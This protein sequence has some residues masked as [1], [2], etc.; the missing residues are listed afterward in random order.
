MP[1]NDLLISI[2]EL[3]IIFFLIFSIVG[4]L[5]LALIRSIIDEYFRDLDREKE[6]W[7]P[8]IDELLTVSSLI[9]TVRRPKTSWEKTG[10][11]L[12]LTE[13]TVTDPARYR[14]LCQIVNRYSIDETLATLYR[15]S[16]I[17]FRKTFYLSTLADLPCSNQR[18]LYLRL[19]RKT[20]SERTYTMAL[21]GLSKSIANA[22]EAEE[23]FRLLLETGQKFYLG[24]NY[25]ELLI[26]I[27]LRHMEPSEIRQAIDYLP[28]DQRIA[29]CVTESLGRFRQ[30]K[31]Q[32]Y[33]R[34]IYRN[35]HRDPEI[36]AALIRSLF[37]SE[38]R[39]CDLMDDLLQ[40]PELPVRINVAKFGLDLCPD[41]DEVMVKL[42]K[43]FF[44]RNYYVRQ[45]VYRA[46]IRH[47]VPAKRIRDI[48]TRHYPEMASDLFFKE[49]MRTYAREEEE[50]K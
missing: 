4:F 49:M 26:H 18:P 25:C 38:A 30:P 10:F 21:Y 42:V 12:A 1:D 7:L 48:A 37:M 43:Y 45:N 16:F 47:H 13:Y 36:V 50:A 2:V 9:Q 6:R 35:F 23:F 17:P 28:M 22:H 31:M 14:Q 19:I 24:R 46:F 8:V 29:R 15:R 33:L 40:R 5:T 39:A 20:R 41:S 11:A 32:S 34:Q 3:A 44:D 27:M